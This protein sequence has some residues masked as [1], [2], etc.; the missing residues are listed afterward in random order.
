LSLL[1]FLYS[2]ES[3][4]NF[5]GVCLH[6]IEIYNLTC[7]RGIVLTINNRSQN[8]HL[9]DDNNGR[10]RA[11]GGQQAVRA[12]LSTIMNKLNKL[13]NSSVLSKIA[14]KKRRTI[15]TEQQQRTHRL[16]LVYVIWSV[17]DWRSW[18]CQ[19]A[20]QKSIARARLT[21][22]SFGQSNHSGS[23]AVIRTHE[24]FLPNMDTRMNV[25]QSMQMIVCHQVDTIVYYDTNKDTCF[26]FVCASRI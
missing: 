17:D 16:D 4:C 10:E 15:T 23:T 14:K 11:C 24:F 19:A 1:F 9:I 12:S 22:D 20:M 13:A 21:A 3:S 26:D 18:S 5:L 7:I 8:T 25:G 2:F 6:S